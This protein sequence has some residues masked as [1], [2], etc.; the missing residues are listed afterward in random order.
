MQKIQDPVI[1][2]NYKVTGYTRVIPIVDHE[3][4]KIK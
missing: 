1:E 4:D 3:D 2:V